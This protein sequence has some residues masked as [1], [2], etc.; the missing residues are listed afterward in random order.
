LYLLLNVPKYAR[1]TGNLLNCRLDLILELCSLVLFL[2]L[3]VILV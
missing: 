1:V 2:R 3:Q